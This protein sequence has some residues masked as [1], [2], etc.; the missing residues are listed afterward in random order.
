MTNKQWI[1]WKM[2]DMDTDELARVLSSRCPE[3]VARKYCKSKYP[4]NGKQPPCYQIIKAWLKQEHEDG[5]CR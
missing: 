2:I 3:C 1:L 5:D 4:I